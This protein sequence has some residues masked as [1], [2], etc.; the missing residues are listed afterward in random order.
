MPDGPPGE[1]PAALLRFEFDVDRPVG[2]A[3]L[4]ATAQG[5]YEAFLN[6]ER[7][8]D[9]EL[10]PGFTQYD[11]RLQVQTYD[12]TRPVRDGPQRARRSCWPTAGSAARSASPAPPTSGATG[13]PLLAQLHLDPRRRHASPWSAPGRG[14]RSAVGHVVAADLI[15]GERCGPDAAAARLGR[16][17]ASTTPAG[18]PSPSVE[19]GYAGLVD[20]P[21][22]PVRRVEELVPVSV[23]PAAT[24][25]CRSSTSARTSTAGSG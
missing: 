7:V 21:A 2:R 12:V 25:A 8:G 19:H 16:G 1:R 9:A 23:D 11:A 20:S 24:A 10:T 22:P 18:T 13:S 3:R 15:A 4:H 14:W 5:I 17:R 6:G